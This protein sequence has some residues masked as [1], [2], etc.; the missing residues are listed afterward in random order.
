M[1]DYIIDI[2][3]AVC[4]T[5]LVAIIVILLKTKKKSSPPATASN[6]EYTVVPSENGT[7][8]LSVNEASS[9]VGFSAVQAISP[10]EERRLVEIKGKQL[11]D[12]IDGVVPGTMQAVVNSAVIANY[13]HSAL[14]SGQV[15]QAILP[16]G[17]KLSKSLHI[18]GAYR[19]FS[20]G[21]NGNI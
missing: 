11:L 20:R 4:A 19:G 7:A 14:A 8:S 21:R 1:Q 18:K 10:I 15:Y 2:C 9:S 3:I 5:L 13:S 16:S 6:P 17:E 12:R